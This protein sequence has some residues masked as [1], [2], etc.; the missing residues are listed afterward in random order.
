MKLN[1]IY[2]LNIGSGPEGLVLISVL[3]MGSESDG[4]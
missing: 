2:E 1:L 4:K 3:E